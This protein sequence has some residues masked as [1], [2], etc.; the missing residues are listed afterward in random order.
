MKFEDGKIEARRRTDEGVELV[1]VVL[2]A[3]M[4]VGGKSAAPCRP[5]NVRRI[6][7]Y[8]KCGIACLTADDLGGDAARYGLGGSPTQVV[9]SRTITADHK[10]TSWVGADDESL[11]DFV[12][13]L[14]DSHIIE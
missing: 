14:V 9:D 6:L 7:N 12:A 13:R 3:V 5:C 4:T 8:R 11:T 2:P 1:S 10:D